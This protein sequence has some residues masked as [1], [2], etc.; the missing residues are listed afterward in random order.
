MNNLQNLHTH[1]S[2]CD[3]KNSPR[4]IIEYAI[5]KELNSIGFSEHSFMSYSPSYSMSLETTEEYIKEI[6]SLKNEF[7][8]RFSVFCG[9]EMDMYSAIDLSPYEYKIGS[10]HYLK[11]DGEYI[12]I[13]RNAETLKNV[14][15]IYFDGNGLNCAEKYYETLSQLYNYGDFDIIGHFDIITKNY[16]STS[17]FDVEGKEY[18]S[19]AFE[20]AK[21]LKGKIPFFEVNTGAI[22]RGYRT[23]PYP[24]LTLLKELHK[25]GFG[26]VISSDCH[27]MQHLTCSFTLATELLKQAGFKEK[28]ILTDNGFSSVEL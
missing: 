15:D 14:I 6:Y 1:T 27:D 24:T 22:A 19:L 18:L 4:E 8:D 7:K 17:F 16:E 10:V 9:I 21:S 25:L 13:D 28:I 20:A 5:S 12:G 3:G 11:I 2:F 26:A 23:S